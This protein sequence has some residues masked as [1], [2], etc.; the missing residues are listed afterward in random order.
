VKRFQS[1]KLCGGSI[2]MAPN[3]RIMATTADD[4]SVMIW[5]LE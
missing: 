5:M 4:A 2:A 3:G 1:H